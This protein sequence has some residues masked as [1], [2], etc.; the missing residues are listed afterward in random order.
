MKEPLAKGNWSTRFRRIAVNVG[1]VWRAKRARAV[2]RMKPQ[3]GKQ[4]V[5]WCT[6]NDQRTSKSVGR[7]PDASFTGKRRCGRYFLLDSSRRRRDM[8]PADGHLLG[9]YLSRRCSLRNY[10]RKTGDIYLRH[11][12]P[13]PPLRQGW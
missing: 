9:I 1:P 8:C 5:S 12:L 4:I 6:T 11:K 2:L 10:D 3:T 13:I 7:W